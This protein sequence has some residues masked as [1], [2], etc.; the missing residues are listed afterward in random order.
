MCS[1][2][3]SIWETRIVGACGTE[4]YVTPGGWAVLP[5]Q[6]VEAFVESYETVCLTNT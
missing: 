5:V 1:S 6:I 4:R 2:A 3:L